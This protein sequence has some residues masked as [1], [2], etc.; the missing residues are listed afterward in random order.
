MKP[1]VGRIVHF[2]DNGNIAAGII[3]EC[4]PSA[5][6]TRNGPVNIAEVQLLGSHFDGK[7]SF[8][9]LLYDTEHDAREAGDP[10]AFFWPER[11][12]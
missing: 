2:R 4:N 6:D 9:T 8:D 1:T 12:P 11:T 10:H 3:T 7:Y 5:E